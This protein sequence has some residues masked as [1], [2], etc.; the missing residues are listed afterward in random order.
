[1]CDDNTLETT[2]QIIAIGL[3]ILAWIVSFI[4]LRRSR[5]QNNE[6]I[7]FQNKIDV[8]RQIISQTYDFLQ[9]SYFILDELPD[10]KGNKEEWTETKMPELYRQLN[11]MIDK[12]DS[13]FIG[14]VIFLPDDFIKKYNEF[15]FKCQRL[16][17]EHYH[18]DNQVSIETYMTL[19]EM[20]NDLI[21]EVRRDLHVDLLNEKL[22]YRLQK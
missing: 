4:Q 16:L 18:F 8:Y 7:I 10:F 5:R 19:T 22:K 3:A 2:I 15:S 21:N 11:P 13:D 1:M 14:H 9:K 17:V 6:D 20:H 12:M